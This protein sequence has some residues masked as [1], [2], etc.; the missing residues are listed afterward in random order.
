[1]LT[2]E[3]AGSDPLL[4]EGISYAIEMGGFVA[5]QIADVFERG[6]FSMKNYTGRF[7]WSRVGKEMLALTT[8]SSWFYSVWHK[9]FLK[10]GL[11][12]PGL[13]AKGGE[14]LAGE[15]DPKM[16]V[17]AKIGAKLMLN[18]F[19]QTFVPSFKMP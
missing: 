17:A 14:I 2:G 15:L 8:M 13:C 9:R 7:H 6:D 4:A 18:F 10:A 5:E 19:K 16:K 12:D 11:F 3:A 1:M